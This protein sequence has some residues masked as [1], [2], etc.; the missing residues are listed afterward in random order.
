MTTSTPPGTPPAPAWPSPTPISSQR[1]AWLARKAHDAAAASGA[2][3]SL[4]LSSWAIGEIT[5]DTDPAQARQHLQRAVDLATPVGSP[6][7]VA[8]AEVS[9]ATLHARHGE[10]LD[11][12]QVIDLAL[13]AIERATSLTVTD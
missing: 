2:P 6:L 9:L 12:H 7:V 3:S 11:S 1:R 8:L 5:A 4:A 10:R 13:D